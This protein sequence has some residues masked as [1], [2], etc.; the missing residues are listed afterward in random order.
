MSEDTVTASFKGVNDTYVH[1][2]LANS[3]YHF[4]KRFEGIED[5][6]GIN[7]E[8]IAALTMVAFRVEA[9]CNFIGD[10]CLDDW[11][12]RKTLKQK[13]KALAKGLGFEADFGKEPYCT[14]IEDVKFFRDMMAHGKPSSDAIDEKVVTTQKSL[15]EQSR[16][17][18]TEWEQ[19]V[20]V[21][22]FNNAYESSEH[23]WRIL[24]E[25][26]G[27]DQIDAN[28][29]GGTTLIIGQIEK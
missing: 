24:I 27:V 9:D 28:S 14:I 5:K 11:D 3:A 23:F 18:L 21:E 2:Y 1:S 20:N 10:R 22:F 19:L 17:Y 26:S 12:D 29:Y 25:H 13:I 8:I 16:D 7:L 15:N 6:S 4:R